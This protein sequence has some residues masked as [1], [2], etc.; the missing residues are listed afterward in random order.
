MALNPGL[1][2]KGVKNTKFYFTEKHF[3][4]SGFPLGPEVMRVKEAFLLK[5]VKR[6]T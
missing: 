3:F 1:Y 5:D 2:V 6:R 4:C